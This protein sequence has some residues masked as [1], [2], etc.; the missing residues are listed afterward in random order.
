MKK[1]FLLIAL[2]LLLIGFASAEDTCGIEVETCA[3]E[4]E[5]TTSSCAYLSIH[6]RNDL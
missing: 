5:E 4:Y 6:C 3:V 2:F 1:I